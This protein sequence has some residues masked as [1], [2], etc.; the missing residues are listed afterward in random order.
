VNTPILTI[1]N[2]SKRYQD[3][4]ALTNLSLTFN[5]GEVIALLGANG[6]G[7]STLINTLLGLIKA[8]SGDISIAGYPPGH[9]FSR[10]QIGCMMQSTQLPTTLTVYEHIQLFS[11]YYPNPHP[12]NETLKLA[13]LTDLSSRKLDQLSGGQ[14]QRVYFALAICGNPQLIF[15][16]EPSVGLDISA[17]EVLWQ[18]I[19]KLR[20]QGKT[21]LLTTH[22]LEEAEALANR[23]IYL[24]LGK[25]VFDGSLND[26]KSQ[27][28]AK[29]IR[30]KSQITIQQIE[31]LPELES[32]E[33]RGQHYIVTSKRCET[34]LQSLFELDPLLSDLT[35]VQR[36][37][38][39]IVKNLQRPSNSLDALNIRE[40]SEYLAAQSKVK[41]IQEAQS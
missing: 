11:S 31:N 6:A 39:D 5:K 9:I 4:T 22:Y 41:E 25:V 35:V 17:R 34:T 36:S 14:K 21:I 2:L 40:K 18:C 29:S 32:V 19:E 23:L 30:F 28:N 8:Q 20:Q 10:Q 33:Q 12:V 26:F 16:D 1:S 15:L 38:E 7:K 3:L 13:Q 27:Y 37:L 24:T